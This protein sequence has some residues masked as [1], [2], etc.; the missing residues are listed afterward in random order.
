MADYTQGEK[1]TIA[2]ATYGS[3][4][5]VSG[6]AG[7]LFAKIKEG[8]AGLKTV[9]K[10]ADW[11]I[12]SIEGSD[13]G[14]DI[15]TDSDV[16]EPKVMAALPEAARIVAA[17]DPEHAEAYKTVVVAAVQEAAEAAKGVNEAEADVIA[18]VKGA[19]GAGG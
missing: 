7:G 8:V 14:S 2:I 16:L 17:K 19:L 15:A 3:V 5:L 11:L 10:E 4:A 1:N 13:V 12:K 18:K 6:E 9:G